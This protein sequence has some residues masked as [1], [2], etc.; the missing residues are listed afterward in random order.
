MMK[1][2]LIN[3]GHLLHYNGP[4]LFTSR[5]PLELSLFF[6]LHSIPKQLY[7]QKS[8]VSSEQSEATHFEPDFYSHLNAVSPSS[9]ATP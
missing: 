1:Q 5:R 9:Y 2:K 6:S 3:V 8:L 4:L 7:T